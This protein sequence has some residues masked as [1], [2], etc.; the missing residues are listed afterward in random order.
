MA[1]QSNSPSFEGLFYAAI[2]HKSKNATSPE[3]KIDSDI[4]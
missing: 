4:C 1:K 3:K 2:L